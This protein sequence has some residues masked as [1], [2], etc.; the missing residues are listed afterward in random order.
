M[1]VDAEHTES[2]VRLLLDH[3]YSQEDAVVKTKIAG[4]LSELAKTPRFKSSML[5]DD[6]TTILSKEGKSLVLG[7]IP[8][9]L[10]PASMKWYHKRSVEFL[11]R[12][13]LLEVRISLFIG[14][15]HA[16]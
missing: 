4:V 14:A 8:L 2:I 11:R 10:Q 12:D 3:F 15:S 1:P 6:I 7:R 13:C 5:V 16:I 9:S